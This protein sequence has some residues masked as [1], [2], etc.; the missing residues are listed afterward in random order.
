MLDLR[1]W[2]CDDTWKHRPCGK[3]MSPGSTPQKDLFGTPK[4]QTKSAHIHLF[5]ALSAYISL[6]C[7]ISCLFG[8]HRS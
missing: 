3:L 5:V 4:S 1:T 6:I 8:D 7:Q 2:P